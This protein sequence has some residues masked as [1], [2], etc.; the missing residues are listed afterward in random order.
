MPYI[1]LIYIY[2]QT[3]HTHTY[4][5]NVSEVTLDEKFPK[6]LKRSDHTLLNTVNPK[7]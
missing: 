2:I 1:K 4:T 3:L 7:Q 5:Y 6:L